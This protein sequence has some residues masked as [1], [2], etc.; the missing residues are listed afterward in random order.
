[1]GKNLVNVLAFIHEHQIAHRD[2]KPGNLV[3][4]DDFRLQIIDFDVAI[5][6]RDEN[7]EIDEYYGTS[8]GL[9]ST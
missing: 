4:D 7:T 5:K 2:I 8:L 1:L 3:C 9:D 6:V